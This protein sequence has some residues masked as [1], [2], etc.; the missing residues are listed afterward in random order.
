MLNRI[1][2]NISH[3]KLSE[4]LNEPFELILGQIVLKHPNHSNV[5]DVFAPT[6][7]GAIKPLIMSANITELNED[8][9]RNPRVIH[10]EKPQLV[11]SGPTRRVRNHFANRRLILGLH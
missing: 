9:N 6:D 7:L 8:L 2:L 10:I 1:R 11:R 5:V 4:F 3:K